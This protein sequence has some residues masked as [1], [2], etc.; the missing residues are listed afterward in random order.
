[1]KRVW[2][3][4]SCTGPCTRGTPP[5]PGGRRSRPRRTCA[6]AEGAGQGENE[7]RSGAFAWSVS[8]SEQA[9][10]RARESQEKKRGRPRPGGCVSRPMGY[11]AGTGA[12]PAP[13]GRDTA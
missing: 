10:P 3:K 2:T 13:P 9:T 12:R 6:A 7:H 1:V 8:S 11:A 5:A 4:S